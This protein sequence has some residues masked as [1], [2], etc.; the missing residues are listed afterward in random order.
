MFGSGS[1]ATDDRCVG[2][3]S[4]GEFGELV[5]SMSVGESD[6][7][8]C[9]PPRRS[10]SRSVS[11]SG[12]SKIL[13]ASSVP[14]SRRLVRRS[15]FDTGIPRP[16]SSPRDRPRPLDSLSSTEGQHRFRSDSVPFERRRPRPSLSG[17]SSIRFAF[18]G[19]PSPELSP[20]PGTFIP[21]A[22]CGSC[23]RSA[24]GTGA[25]SCAAVF[26]VNRLTDGM[27]LPESALLPALLHVGKS[28]IREE[29]TVPFS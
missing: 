24:L 12:R 17:E 18:K 26:Y 22:L 23:T 9:P 7:A 15:R 16:S 11:S 6:R 3:R 29:S 20:R 25:G 10:G 27:R 19:A 14:P 13:S 28:Q 8:A 5:L 2:R 4:F 1:R 21:G